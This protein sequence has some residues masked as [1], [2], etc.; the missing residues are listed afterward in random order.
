MI[1][2]EIIEEYLLDILGVEFKYHELDSTLTSDGARYYFNYDKYGRSNIL[3]FMLDD[4]WK[5]NLIN[6]S[7]YLF[8]K[9]KLRDNDIKVWVRK[10]KLEK[11]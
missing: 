9:N 11:L 8:D 3:G 6:G 5:T 2:N 4:K 1:S 7:G 10:K